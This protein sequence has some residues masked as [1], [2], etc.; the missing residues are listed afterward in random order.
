[1]MQV[2]PPFLPPILAFF[3]AFTS[4]VAGGVG[5]AVTFHTLWALCGAIGVLPVARLRKAVLYASIVPMSNMPLMVYRAIADIRRFWRWGVLVAVAAGIMTPIGAHLLLTVDVPLVKR[6]AGLLFLG[7]G[8]IQLHGLL[9]S[10]D[11]SAGAQSATSKLAALPSSQAL[12]QH[13]QDGFTAEVAVVPRNAGPS[14]GRG[15][16]RAD[17][18]ALPSTAGDDGF[19]TPPAYQSPHGGDSPIPAPAPPLAAAPRWLASWPIVSARYS[20]AVS[21]AVLVAGG[22]VS[23]LL[24][25]MLGTS[26]PPLIVAYAFLALDK[27]AIRGV[28]VTM[29]ALVIGVRMWALIHSP[30]SVF[31]WAG[32]WHVYAGLVACSWAGLSAGAAVREYC[33][34]RAILC[35]LSVLLVASAAIMLGALEEAMVAGAMVLLAGVGAAAALFQR[36]AKAATQPTVRS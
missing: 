2:V 29:Q 21:A 1:M 35:V 4:S 28:T 3:A 23:G 16:A 33:D 7:F 22:L 15:G 14:R 30:G 25:G 17:A 24:G 27:D 6:A 11:S 12:E 34:S 20:Q 31:D 26:G 5:D 8:I 36:Q 9:V 10:S 13:E 18:I 19:H 32:E